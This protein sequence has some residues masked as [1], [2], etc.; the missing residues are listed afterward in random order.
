MI[1]Q[2]RQEFEQLSFPEIEFLAEEE[3]VDIIPSIRTEEEVD[4]VTGRYGPF[5]PGEQTQVPLWMASLLRKKRQC[6]L[7]L[8]DWMREDS[9]IQTLNYEQTQGQF[10]TLPFRYSEIAKLLLDTG[11]EDF[12]NSQK[13]RSLIHDIELTRKTKLEA[14]IKQIER[15]EELRVVCS[16]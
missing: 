14:S 3:I 13:L 5:R 15:A 10:S 16:F 7:C 12:Q 2:E 4:V 11:S 9:L 6:T 1:N 8:P